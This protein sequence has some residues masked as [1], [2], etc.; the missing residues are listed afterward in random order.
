MAN[1]YDTDSEWQNT[2]V[3]DVALWEA[4][5]LRNVAI[6]LVLTLIMVFMILLMFYAN[7]NFGLLKLLLIYYYNLECHVS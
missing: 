1:R 2:I 5:I 4:I 6:I 3:V 7:F